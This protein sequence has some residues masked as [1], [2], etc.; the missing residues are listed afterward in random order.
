MCPSVMGRVLGFDTEVCVFSAI[1]MTVGFKS[2]RRTIRCW[3]INQLCLCVVD[4]PTPTDQLQSPS[5]SPI[6][7]LTA[8]MKGFKLRMDEKQ[9]ENA[10]V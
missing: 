4:L 9:N 5:G 1:W 3:S 6:Y 8:Q 7:A 2:W 10:N